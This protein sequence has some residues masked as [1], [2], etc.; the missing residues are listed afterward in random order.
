M[1]NFF[2]GEVYRD[3]G[4]SDLAYV[5]NID[6]PN[7]WVGNTILIKHEYLRPILYFQLDNY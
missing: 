1:E 7:L 4:L 5:I 3:M 2:L 6:S